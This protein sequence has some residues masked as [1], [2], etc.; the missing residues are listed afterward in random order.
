ML[1]CFNLQTTKIETLKLLNFPLAPSKESFICNRRITYW[2]VKNVMCAVVTIRT[3]H[4]TCFLK[5]ALELKQQGQPLLIFNSDITD[6]ILDGMGYV[7]PD[8]EVVRSLKDIS[9]YIPV[10]VENRTAL[11]Q[12]LFEMPKIDYTQ[13]VITMLKKR[14]LDEILKAPEPVSD[15]EQGCVVCYVNRA[16]VCFVDCGH[17]VLCDVCVKKLWTSVKRECP[18]CRN[19]SFYIVR[20]LK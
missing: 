17:Q 1:F 14:K 16:S 4:K 11:S 12:L 18:V 10:P 13:V 19:P 2:L 6:T 7:P 3:Q 20:P 8:V 15:G 5:K 9:Y